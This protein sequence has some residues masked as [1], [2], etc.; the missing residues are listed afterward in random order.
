MVSVLMN[1][2]L[3]RIIVFPATKHE[4]ILEFMQDHIEFHKDILAHGFFRGFVDGED[5]KNTQ[6][7]CKTGIEYRMGTAEA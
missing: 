7:I 3:L 4:E 6:I 1:S 2:I 5:F